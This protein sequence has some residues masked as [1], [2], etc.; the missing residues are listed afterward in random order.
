MPTG[1]TRAKENKDENKNNRIY[2]SRSR[3]YSRADDG[4]LGFGVWIVEGW[5]GGRTEYH[6]HK[7]K[8]YLVRAV[9]QF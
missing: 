2:R 8:S 9:R 4:G 5:I 6:Q 3:G 1:V 7:N